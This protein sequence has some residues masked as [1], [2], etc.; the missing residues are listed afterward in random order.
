MLRIHDSLWPV[1]TIFLALNLVIQSPALA[2]NACEDRAITTTA[3]VSVSDGSRF[4]T[5]TW[6]QAADHAAIRHYDEAVQTVAV[7]GPLAWISRGERFQPGGDQLKGFAL[8]HQYHALL[9]HFSEIVADAEPVKDIVFQG[10]TRSGIG[11][12]YPFGGKIFLVHGAEDDKP[13][14]FRFEL[15]ASP[16]MEIAF[17]D[18]RDHQG[19]NLPFHVAIDDASLVYEYD[20]RDIGIGERAPGWFY[21]AVEAPD[22]D[23]VQIHRLHR[24]LLAAHCSGDAQAMAGLTA[25]EI[26]VSSRGEMRPS[27]RDEVG[28][29]FQSTFERLDYREYHDLVPPV[30]EASE[31][32]DLGWLAV[33]VRALGLEQSTEKPFD[34][35]WSWIMLVRKIEG[36]WLHAGNASNHRPV[37]EQN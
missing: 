28:E 13:A 33:Q 25:P 34:I 9:L 20:Y 1:A 11:G 2:S 27:T 6:F 18:W 19:R 12:G 8:G 14:G 17:S 15:P 26:V 29:R 31:N 21:E 30:I 4:E 7:E 5:E 37:N 10:Q 3:S 23:P 32:G 22:I 36:K 24:R 16:P 35:Q